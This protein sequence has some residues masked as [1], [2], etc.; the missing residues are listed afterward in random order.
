MAAL[1]N[2][3]RPESS[4]WR[5]LA[6]STNRPLYDGDT[7][8]G[9]AGHAEDWYLCLVRRPKRYFGWHLRPA[10]SRP[11]IEPRLF[12]LSV[13][14]LLLVTAPCRLGGIEAARD[15]QFHV[16]SAP[17]CP[18]LASRVQDPAATTP[19]NKDSLQRLLVL[20]TF[21]GDIPR[22]AIAWSIPFAMLTTDVKDRAF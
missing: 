11:R 7:F 3:C 2:R 8:V 19:Y 13:D 16:S 18:V 20:S 22:N 17:T 15:A 6:G 10:A 5:L 1:C 12:P 9:A 14:S 4:T 21:S